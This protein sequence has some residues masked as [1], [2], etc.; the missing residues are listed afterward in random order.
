MGDLNVDGSLG[1]RGHITGHMN[2]YTPT[3]NIWTRSGNIDTYEGNMR[4]VI[5]QFTDVFINSSLQLKDNVSKLSIEE[6]QQIINNLEP[7]KFCFKNDPDKGE[8]IGFIA[9]KVPDI[10]ASKDHKQ[11]RYME[12]ISALT[13]VVKEQQKTIEEMNIRLS[14]LISKM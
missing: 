3:G 5:G 14:E 9:E 7:I 4:A 13:K 8:N 11:V 6:A 10:I 12:I 2:I 1:V